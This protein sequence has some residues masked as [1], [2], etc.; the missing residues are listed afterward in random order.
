MT[1]R[2][3]IEE[4]E[5]VLEGTPTGRDS[6]VS[7]SW[8]RCVELYGMDPLRTEPAHIVTETEL[9]AHRKQAEWMISAARSGLQSLFRQVAGQNC[10]AAHRCAG[11]L[12]RF[13]W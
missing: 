10:A 9:R 7:A 13:F 11:G 8:R 12:R 2:R 3:H 5:R 6:F 1:E 4:I